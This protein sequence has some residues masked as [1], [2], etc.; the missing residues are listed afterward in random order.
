MITIYSPTKNLSERAHDNPVKESPVIFGEEMVKAIL[1]GRK[2]MTRRIVKMPE[3][4]WSWDEYDV[5]NFLG[6]WE[7]V[8]GDTWLA[9]INCPYGQP[10]D[11]LWVRENFIKVP[12]GCKIKPVAISFPDKCSDGVL[13]RLRRWPSIHLKKEDAR[14]WLEVTEVRVEQLQT[15][16]SDDSIA[17]GIESWTEERMR[18]KPTHYKV[19]HQ[20]TPEDPAFY[21]SSPIDSFETLWQCIHGADAWKENPLVWVIS[22]NVLSTTGRPEIREVQ[23]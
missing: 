11:M 20:E 18:S 1:A 16:S 3:E 12:T 21:S 23:S 9:D 5:Q 15:I 6:N 13:Q 10:G 7:F 17:E 22:F 2:T 19:Y 8:A 4:S 14:I